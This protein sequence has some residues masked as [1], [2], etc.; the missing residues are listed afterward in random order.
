[1]NGKLRAAFKQSKVLLYKKSHIVPGIR[2]KMLQQKAL[3][4][5]VEYDQRNCCVAVNK[6]TGTRKVAFPNR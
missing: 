5:M 6:L 2:N 4:G 3:P 1:M